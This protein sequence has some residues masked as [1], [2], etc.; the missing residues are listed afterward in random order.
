[1]ANQYGLPFPAQRQIARSAEEISAVNT[2]R[3]LVLQPVL[4]YPVLFQKKPN[5]I[6]TRAEG[7]LMD[8]TYRLIPCAYPQRFFVRCFIGAYE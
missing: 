4:N 6:A 8:L 7:K 5:L 3:Y 2:D 1:M